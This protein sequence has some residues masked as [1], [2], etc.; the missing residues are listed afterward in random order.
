[1]SSSLPRGAVRRRLVGD[2]AVTEVLGAEGW[3]SKQT[4]PLGL[5]EVPP[6]RDPS[7]PDG[8]LLPFAPVSFRDFM[9]Y[10]Q[11]VV[12]AS[13]GM[14][15]RYLPG[16]AGLAAA[17]ERSTR[18]VFPGY[19]PNRLWREQPI[20]YFGNPL[21][22]VPSGTPIAA[23]RYARHLD[24]ELELGCVLGR[25]LRDATPEEADTAIVA[26]VVV[27]DL[28]ARDVQLREMRSGFGPQK[29]KHFAS[30]LS[31]T[32]VPRTAVGAL[33]ALSAWVRIDGEL[34]ATS[35]T[36]GWWHSIA[37]AIAHASASEQLYPGELFATGTL[38]GCCGLENG[39]L[40][41]PNQHL[42]LGIA[43]VGT[44][45]HRIVE[46]EGERS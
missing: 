46:T 43:D 2:V 28:S 34:V 22:F 19:R 21:T 42:E 23:P 24:Y 40:L 6:W 17:Y 26:L 25:P 18:R 9:L 30:S 33:D 44:I 1:M 38:P 14:A 20:Y 37:E 35:S 31:A 7:A 32:L 4:A 8:T 3:A 12:G 10:E 5:P 45:E 13:R 16:V 29:S 27:N 36:G 11:H 39:R 41:A 15:R